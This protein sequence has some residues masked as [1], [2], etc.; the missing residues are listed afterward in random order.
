MYYDAG[1][2]AAYFLGARDPHNQSARLL[3]DLIE[4]GKKQGVVSYLLIMETTHAI[5]KRVVQH[6]KKTEPSSA[7]GKA[8]KTS[9]LFNNYV[10]NGLDVGRLILVKPDNPDHGDKVFKKASSMPGSV[11]NNAYRALG[12]AGVEHAYLA[13]YA[14]ASELHTTDTSFHALD[15]DPD[16]SVKFIVWHGKSTRT[17]VC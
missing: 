14:G 9:N 1:V 6:S 17:N 8:V 3:V 2:W 4:A 15:G 5:R 13:D 10:M 12:H 11:K 16:F 7:M